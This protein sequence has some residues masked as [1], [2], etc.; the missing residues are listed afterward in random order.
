MQPLVSV[1]VTVAV[2]PGCVSTVRGESVSVAPAHA[3]VG[4]RITGPTVT[5]WPVAFA[6][7]AVRLNVYGVNCRSPP[8]VVYMPRVLSAHSTVCP[9]NVVVGTPGAL[10]VYPTTGELPTDDGGLK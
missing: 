7:T 5:G 6:F 9:V 8:T 10:M 2:E 4:A 1:A 3:V